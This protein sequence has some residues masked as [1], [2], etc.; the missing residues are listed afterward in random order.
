MHKSARTVLCGGAASNGRPY[1]DRVALHNPREQSDEL[2][3]IPSRN[4][5][6]FG[7]NEPSEGNRNPTRG[8]A[9]VNSTT[10]L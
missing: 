4:T 9:G 5:S 10:E 6:V 1:R 3:R 7:W 8:S 2:E